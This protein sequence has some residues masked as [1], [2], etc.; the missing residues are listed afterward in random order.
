MKF[1]ISLILKVALLIGL[2][3][4]DCATG[5]YK[6]FVAYKLNTEGY[7][8]NTTTCNPKM[9][10]IAAL[11]HYSDISGSELLY[12]FET[13][14]STRKLIL[15]VINFL[16]I[17]KIELI[18]LNNYKPD[19]TLNP[20]FCTTLKKKYYKFIWFALLFG[21]F[22][23]LIICLKSRYGIRI[24][25]YS[26]EVLQQRVAEKTAE[27]NHTVEQLIISREEISKS[28]KEKELLLR[29]IH[30][31]IKN[32]LQLIISLLHIQSKKLGYPS[33][34]PFITQNESR[35]LSMALIHKNLY[36][37]ENLERVD[38]NDYL[39]NLIPSV[40]NLYSTDSSQINVSLENAGLM[41]HIQTAIPLG[42]MISEIIN[43]SCKYARQEGNDLEIA[44]SIITINNTYY[45]TIKDNGPGFNIEN[46]PYKSF[47]IELIN[48]LGQQL[49]GTIDINTSNGVTYTISF[50]DIGLN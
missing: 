3:D 39:N 21:L 13:R 2:N 29:E 26:E 19:K 37:F 23:A 20:H 32:N 30:H 17:K 27:L 14:K 44:L 36:D 22:T 5:T 15:T 16:K 11:Q 6:T 45:L 34:H 33:N 9:C 41:F 47:G 4:P 1:T 49:K 35:I 42:L 25:V 28:L 8:N 40:I 31:R 43:N 24:N 18:H 50:S 48:L 10:A 7:Y 12:A 46:I 38:F